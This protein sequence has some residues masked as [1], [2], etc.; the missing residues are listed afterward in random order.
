MLSASYRRLLCAPLSREMH[1]LRSRSAGLP[2]GFKFFPKFLSLSEQRTLLSAALFKLDSTESK[3]A[4]KQ[5]RDFLANHPQ[6]HRVIED[7]FL[8]DA[9]YNFQEGHYDGVIRHYREMHLSSWPE[10]QN[11]GLSLILARLQGLY[12]TSN[13]QT[14]LL[15]LSSVGEILEHVDNIEASG[16]WILGASLGAARLLRMESTSNPEESFEVLLPSG[17]VYL[18]MDSVRYDYKHSVLKA[19]GDIKAG[20]RVSIMIRDRKE[21]PTFN[22]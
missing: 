20:Q 11:P 17:S 7:I 1:T 14:H 16:T 12:P 5:R 19:G 4:R 6:E 21:V 3:Q 18:Q 8:P 9:Y 15:H 22:T 13:I 2:E 10:D